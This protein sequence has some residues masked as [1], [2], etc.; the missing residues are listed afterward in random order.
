MTKVLNQ[1]LDKVKKFELYELGDL[2]HV[3]QDKKEELQNL[4]SNDAL[5]S[6]DYCEEC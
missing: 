4:S 5:K 3:C 1:S 6:V 2:S